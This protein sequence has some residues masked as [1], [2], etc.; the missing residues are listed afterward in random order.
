M[1]ARREESCSKEEAVTDLHPL[2]GQVRE[3][4]SV[5]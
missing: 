1:E 4:E 5:S 3:Y 2:E